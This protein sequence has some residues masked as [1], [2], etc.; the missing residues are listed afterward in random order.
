[1]DDARPVC[2]H[3]GE[4]VL[5]LQAMNDIIQLL[6]VSGEEYRPRPWSVSNANNVALHDIRAICCR[7]ERLVVPAGSI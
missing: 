7:R 4:E 1:M 6:A 5:R 2:A 3:C